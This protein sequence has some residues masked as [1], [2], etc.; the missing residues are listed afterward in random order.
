MEDSRFISTGKE[1]KYEVYADNHEMCMVQGIVTD[2]IVIILWCAKYT[3]YCSNGRALCCSKC[4][5]LL[6]LA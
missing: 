2:N 1:G 3:G 5:D 6:R 4:Q